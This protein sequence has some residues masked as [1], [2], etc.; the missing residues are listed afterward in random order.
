MTPEKI[1][2]EIEKLQ[3]EFQKGAAL[4]RDTQERMLRIEGAIIKLQEILKEMRN[5]EKSPDTDTSRLVEEI[6]GG[7][8]HPATAGI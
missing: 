8:K 5:V 4:V 2:N 1:E 7:K 6:A 3:Q